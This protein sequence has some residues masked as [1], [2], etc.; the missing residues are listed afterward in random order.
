MLEQPLIATLQ[1]T[2]RRQVYAFKVIC[3]TLA[4]VDPNNFIDLGWNLINLVKAAA[5]LLVKQI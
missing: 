4:K 1:R 2:A 3:N 5:A